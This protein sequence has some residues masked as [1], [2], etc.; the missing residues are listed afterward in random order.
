MFLSLIKSIL[1]PSDHNNGI[2]GSVTLTKK[3]QTIY[4]FAWMHTHFHEYY[5]LLYGNI[6]IAVN[7]S[8]IYRSHKM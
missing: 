8:Y 4:I 5:S 2:C 6:L 1:F 7:M 3:P